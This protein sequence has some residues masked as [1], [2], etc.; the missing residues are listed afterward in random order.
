MPFAVERKTPNVGQQQ[1]PTP[2][3]KLVGCLSVYRRREIERS[4]KWGPYV[5]S[6]RRAE[7]Y[8]VLMT[9]SIALVA[10]GVLLFLAGKFVV[11]HD[12]WSLL[13][14]FVGLA[15][16]VYGLLKPY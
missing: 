15:L 14:M 8:L 6:E 13:L 7:R 2:T 9:L 16:V 11:F 10:L 3:H 12:G 4:P 5:G 1:P